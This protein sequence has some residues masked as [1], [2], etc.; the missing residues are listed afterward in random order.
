MKYLVAMFF[1]A[2]LSACVTP[3]ANTAGTASAVPQQSTGPSD[4]RRAT[5][6]ACLAEIGKDPLPEVL[7]GINAPMDRADAA[8]FGACM[9]RQA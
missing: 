6:N 4:E 7:S 3:P 8:V 1:T 2:S 5:I 9:D